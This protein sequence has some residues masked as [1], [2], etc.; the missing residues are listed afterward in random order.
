MEVKFLII[1]FSPFLH[2]VPEKEDKKY[3]LHSFISYTRLTS[4]A[5]Y[6]QTKYFL[7]LILSMHKIEEEKMVILSFR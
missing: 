7:N 1:P 6:G 2:F 3:S 4:F 5:F